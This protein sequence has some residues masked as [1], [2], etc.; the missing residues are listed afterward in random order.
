MLE[1]LLVLNVNAVR[2]LLAVAVRVIADAPKI[3]GEA[4]A[5]VT[6]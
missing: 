4:G 1:A 5:K 3:T 2:L 6:V